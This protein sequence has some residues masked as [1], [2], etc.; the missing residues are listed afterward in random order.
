MSI[1]IAQTPFGTIA[2]EIFPCG[3]RAYRLSPLGHWDYCPD[4]KGPW[5]GVTASDVP[6][7]IKDAIEAVR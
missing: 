2:R 5:L 1:R 6:E 3:E 4:H 7:H